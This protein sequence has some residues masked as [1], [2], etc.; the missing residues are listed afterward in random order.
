FVYEPY[1]LFWKPSKKVDPIRVHGEMY[2]SPAFVEAHQHLQD[3]PPEPGCDLP[4]FITACMFGSDLTHLTSFGDTKLWPCYLFYGNDSQYRR[5]KPSERTCDHVAYFQKLPEDFINFAKSQTG[6]GKAPNPAFKTFCSRELMHAQLSVL[7][8]DKF[9][10][11]WKHGIVVEC[12]DG[13]K[14][15]FYPRIFTYAA[16]YPEKILLAGV[17]NLGKCPCPRCLMPMSKAGET[18]TKKDKKQRVQNVRR[19]DAQRRKAVEEARHLIY[20]KRNQVNSAAV[21]RILQPKLLVPNIS[22]LAHFVSLCLTC[23]W[24]C[25]TSVA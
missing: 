19:D 12:C 4:R 20:H 17:R 1:E 15:R 24:S 16:D 8:D 2:T 10:E 25:T 22:N 9:I 3:S 14:R 5:C 21:E 23:L 7:F 11:A 18:G 6:G 13:I